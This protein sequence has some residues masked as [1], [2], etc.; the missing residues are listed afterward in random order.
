[1]KISYDHLLRFFSDKPSIDSISKSLF[2]LGHENEY[3][4]NILDIEFTPNRGD[5]LSLLGLSRDLS[6][7]YELN[8]PIEVYDG[9]IE[10]LD[11]NFQNFSHEDCQSLSFLNI[12]IDKPI[13]KYKPYLESYFKDLSNNKINFFTDVSNYIAYELGQPTHCYDFKKLGDSITLQNIKKSQSF[14]TLTN[15]KIDLAPNDLVFISN[16]EVINLAGVMGGMQSSCSDSTNNVL[17]ECAY[18][19]PEAI[20]GKS[21][22]YDLQSDASY[23]FERGVD[24]LIHAKC[25]RR[26]IQ[27]V[28]DHVDIKKLAIFSN[29]EVK[30]SPKKIEYD[31]SY[32]SKILGMNLT[33][34]LCKEILLKLGFTFNNHGALIVPSY[35]NDI[36]HLNDIAEEIARTIG[37]DNIKR[38]EF[39]PLT[40]SNNKNI[41]QKESS[42]TDFLV[43]NGFHEVIN[44]P[45]TSIKNEFSISIDNPIDTNK[46][47][48][49]TKIKES[50]IENLAFNENRQK[51]SIKIFEI[52]DVYSK[53]NQIKKDKKLSLIIS[54]R[55]GY[56]FKEFSKKLDQDYI[57]NIFN[58][59]NIN[60]NKKDIQEISRNT[61]KSKAKDKIYF[62]EIDLIDLPESISSYTKKRISP[63]TFSQKY[64]VISDQPSSIRD[65]S[66]TLYDPLLIS[67]LE[68]L[69]LNYSS[70]YLKDVFIF[71]FFENKKN[72]QIKIG[73]RFTFQSLN[74][75]I[76]FDQVNV[77]INNIINLTKDIKDI[78]I[79][80]LNN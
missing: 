66:F 5:C 68:N 31:Y 34:N 20:I 26:F 11:L 51:D 46:K 69:V 9:P 67:E 41:N 53:T 7:F 77:E 29:E 40:P 43:D 78:K 45:F 18:F 35:R 47:F 61:L 15:K 33:D 8:N 71:D 60:I 65:L 2:Q 6:V 36:F 48:L 75:T 70:K 37:Y 56:N 80:G 23:K 24:P 25:L 54:G 57:I 50:L 38:Q 1:M 44:M 73:F 12:E 14:L 49:R 64:S 79:L 22:R 27:I 30:F 52:A 55:F 28:S 63:P 17:I 42:I 72:N 4:N 16:K 3:S 21:I 76:T 39:K 58:S 19:N 10:T 74:S 32:I 59:V 13:S 62:F